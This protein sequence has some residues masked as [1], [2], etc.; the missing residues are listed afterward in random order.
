MTEINIDRRMGELIEAGYS[1]EDA[2][3]IIDREL[4]SADFVIMD[5][6]SWRDGLAEIRDEFFAN[7]EDEYQKSLSSE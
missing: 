5:D 1:D 2:I 3:A 6:S 7:A 4:E